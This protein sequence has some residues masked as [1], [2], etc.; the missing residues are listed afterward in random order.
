MVIWENGEPGK[1]PPTPFP[2]LH[3]RSPRNVG[4]A[5]G[6]NGAFRALED[7]TGPILLLNP[8]AYPVSPD[9]FDVL[10]E[11]LNHPRV[12]AVA[13]LV[14]YPDGTP[15]IT[16]KP[17]RSA[18]QELFLAR[19][20]LFSWF[21]SPPADLPAEGP[22]E[23][24]TGAVLALRRD[25]F[26]SVGGMDDRFFLFYEDHDLSRRLRKAGWILLFTPRAVAIHQQGGSRGRRALWSQF[27]KI[28]SGMRFA[29]KWESWPP[30]V[31]EV[32]LAVGAGIYAF[33][34]FLGISFMKE[35]R[36]WKPMKKHLNATSPSSSD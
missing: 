17:D 10:A 6:V 21:M 13:P 30:G 5:R 23:V 20:S 26:A 3:I 25:A 29:R 33:L 24:V 11:A 27:Q 15:Q 12:G 28:K 7:T 2:L 34:D 8:D 9:F 14:R 22:V 31:L 4:F 16:V 1:L 32:G 19:T 35:K 36:H 18:L